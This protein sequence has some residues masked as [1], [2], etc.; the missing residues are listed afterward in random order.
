MKEVEGQIL[1][2]EPTAMDI[3]RMD[4]LQTT[5]SITLWVSIVTLVMLGAFLGILILM[6]F[7][8]V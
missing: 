2:T 6:E 3:Y 8:A 7:R 5:V 1:S 4:V